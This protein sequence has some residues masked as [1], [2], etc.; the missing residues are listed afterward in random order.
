MRWFKALIVSLLFLMT[1]VMYRTPS[2]A[3]EPRRR[4]GGDTLWFEIDSMV[5]FEP[6]HQDTSL[7]RWEPPID[8]GHHDQ[9][10]HSLVEATPQRVK[11]EYEIPL[12]SVY[13]RSIRLWGIT[14]ST[15][16]P[17]PFAPYPAQNEQDASVLS[18][19]I[20]KPR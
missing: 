7:F 10:Y 8:I 18:F 6:H 3:Q 19:P 20:P 9:S 16:Q 1:F 12:W 13:R 15:G 5:D 4:M 11:F 2:S 17:S 14:F